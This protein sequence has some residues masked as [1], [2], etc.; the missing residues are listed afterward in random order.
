MPKPRDIEAEA[1]VDDTVESPGAVGL[2]VDA[3]TKGLKVACAGLGE[4]NGDQSMV[5][6]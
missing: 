1:G 3:Y 5:V 2:M 6:S 4:S